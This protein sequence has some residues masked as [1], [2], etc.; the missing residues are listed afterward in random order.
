MNIRDHLCAI[1]MFCVVIT[2]ICCGCALIWNGRHALWPS[3]EN[4]ENAAYPKAINDK[5]KN[6]ETQMTNGHRFPNVQVVTSVTL[7][8]TSV[9]HDTDEEVNETCGN[10]REGSQDESIRDDLRHD[11]FLGTCGIFLLGYSLISCCC[12]IR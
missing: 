5:L 7:V 12:C 10:A 3:E 11:L 1:W 8:D 2:G 4:Q 6:N 9:I